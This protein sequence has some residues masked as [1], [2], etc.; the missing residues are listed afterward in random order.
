M[1]SEP[2]YSKFRLRV[3]IAAYPTYEAGGIVWTYMGPTAEM[4]APPNYEWTRVPPTHLG[5]SKTGEHANFLQ[6][7]EG[8]ID[9][10]HSSFAHNNDI[11]NNKLVRSLDTH[12]TLEV[13]ETDYGFCYGS[14]RN[15]SEDKSYIRVYQFMM[16]N[17]QMRGGLVDHEGNPQKLPAVNGHVWV[18][19]DDENTFVYNWKYSVRED[20]PMSREEWVRQETRGG[21]GPEDFIPGTHWLIRNPSNDYLVDREI[22]R[23][24]TFTGIKG[25]NTQ[26]FALQEGMGGVVRRD[27]EA[28][29]STDMAIAVARKLLLEAMDDVAAGRAPRGSDPE[30]QRNARGA[31]AVVPRGLPWRDATKEIVQATW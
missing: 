19:I 28:L 13:D 7:I 1:P 4:P 9:T 17:Q 2:P 21:R 15:I 8:G 14:I 10:A 20:I 22:Q 25:V 6:A 3:A 26:D 27:L 24:K 29:G 16:P 5:M 12:P 31:D 18:P 23:T 30:T 11:T